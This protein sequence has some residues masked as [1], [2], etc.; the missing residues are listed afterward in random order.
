MSLTSII[1]LLSFASLS[2]SSLPKMFV[3]ALTLC[4]WVV[5]MQFLSILTMDASIVL[6]GWLFC[7]VGCFIWVLMRYSEFRLSVKMYAGS[8]GNSCVR[9]CKVW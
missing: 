5:A 4:R 1:L 8:L 6:F 3:C 2:A 7:C 9:I